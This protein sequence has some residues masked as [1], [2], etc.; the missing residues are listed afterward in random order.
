MLKTQ[1]TD[2][3]APLEFCSKFGSRL[4]MSPDDELPPTVS[5]E[6]CTRRQLIRQ[7]TF[8]DTGTS[9][10]LLSRALGSWFSGFWETKAIAPEFAL[11][12]KNLIVD[13]V[14]RGHGR[15]AE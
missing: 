4:W 6:A 1:P 2:G 13:A 7:G 14:R 11:P 10:R 12:A 15:R 9:E 5:G 8:P 3:S